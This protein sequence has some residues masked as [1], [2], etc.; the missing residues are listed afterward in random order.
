MHRQRVEQ[1]Q[2]ADDLLERFSERETW[3]RRVDRLSVAAF[4]LF[5]SGAIGSIFVSPVGFWH[6]A[7]WAAT[8]LAAGVSARGLARSDT[9]YLA[10]RELREARSRQRLEQPQ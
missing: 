6:Y 9:D 8:V 2:S 5:A 3:R 10:R 7:I 4:P 1:L